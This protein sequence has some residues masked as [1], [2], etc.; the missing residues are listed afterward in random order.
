MKLRI[1]N[2]KLRKSKSVKPGG[3]LPPAP[4]GFGGAGWKRHFITRR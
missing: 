4:R 2:K 1:M 3:G